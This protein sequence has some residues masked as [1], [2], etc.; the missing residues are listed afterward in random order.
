MTWKYILVWN[1]I[2]LGMIFW[3]KMGSKQNMIFWY[4]SEPLW[5][6]KEPTDVENVSVGC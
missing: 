6:V 5:N 4:E 2:D 1:I 3:Y